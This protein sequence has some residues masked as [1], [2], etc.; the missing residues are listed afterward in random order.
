M[1]TIA[2]AFSGWLLLSVVLMFV[3]GWG[4]IAMAAT[5]NTIIQVTTPDAL[6]GRVLSVYTTV[7]AGSSPMGNV[8]TGIIAARAGIS[9]A[10]V[11]GGVIAVACA[12]VVAVWA[13]RREDVLLRRSPDQPATVG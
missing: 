2:L 12:V 9:A 11:I 1:A 13:R 8:A 7:F 5:T 3:V 10:L 4:L 6:R